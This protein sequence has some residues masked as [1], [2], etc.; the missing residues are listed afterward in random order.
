MDVLYL[1][2]RHQISLNNATV[3]VCA[4]AREAHRA[5]AGAYA[6]RIHAERM[7]RPGQGPALLIGG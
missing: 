5:F 3:A 7:G 6:R 2:H 1:L 4:P